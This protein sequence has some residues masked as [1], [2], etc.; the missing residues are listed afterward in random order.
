[1]FVIDYY[2]CLIMMLMVIGAVVLSVTLVPYYGV[3]SLMGFVLLCCIFMSIM[4]RTF[5]ALVTYIVYLGGLIVVFGYCISVEKGSEDV[6][7]ASL[8]KVFV[9]LFVCVG[10]FIYLC[11]VVV[12]GL[13][14]WLVGLGQDCYVCVEVNGFGVLYS[15]GGVG[16][17]VCS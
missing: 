3:I 10:V 16:L 1:M 15:G 7:K 5:I 9:N 4:G 17:I 13:G 14:D 8:S 11:V 12:L 6:F 2:L